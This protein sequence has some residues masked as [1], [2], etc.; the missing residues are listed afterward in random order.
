MLKQF[1]EVVTF[2]KRNKVEVAWWQFK[3]SWVGLRRGNK[4]MLL[5]DWAK[6]IQ[7]EPEVV[8]DPGYAVHI[9]GLGFSPIIPDAFQDSV[10][11]GPR[12][13]NLLP[14][15]HDPS[16][17]YFMQLNNKAYA[18]MHRVFT[19]DV[20]IDK[21]GPEHEQWTCQL[22]VTIPNCA[23]R[24]FTGIESRKMAAKNSA[25]YQALLWL[26]GFGI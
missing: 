1:V 25:S 21:S 9:M 3:S 20:V 14:E 17:H 13:L 24:L 22:T 15:S 8:F 4:T 23:Q 7:P 2:L 11:K 12:F 18:H 16:G 10:R 6:D 26:A 19:F 5:V